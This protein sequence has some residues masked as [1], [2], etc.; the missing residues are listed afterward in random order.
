MN[1]QGYCQRALL[2]LEQYRDGRYKWPLYPMRKAVIL[3]IVHDRKRL[4]VC[5]ALL[6]G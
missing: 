1:S 5:K 6:L 3:D 2:V 4:E